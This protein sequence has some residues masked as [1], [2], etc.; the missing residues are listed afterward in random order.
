VVIGWRE[1]VDSAGIKGW[2]WRLLE[3][4]AASTGV[5]RGDLGVRIGT[6]MNGEDL[7][8]FYRAQEGG[9]AVS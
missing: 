7:G 4:I 3:L 2:W 8:A 5:G 6:V 9:E 1:A